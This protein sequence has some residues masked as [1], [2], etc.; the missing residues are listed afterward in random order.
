MNDNTAKVPLAKV[1]GVTIRPTVDAETA[2]RF[3]F[4][5]SDLLEDLYYTVKSHDYVLAKKIR[6]FQAKHALT[7]GTLT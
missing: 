7:F 4:E 2:I 6:D 5:V 3:K 1:A